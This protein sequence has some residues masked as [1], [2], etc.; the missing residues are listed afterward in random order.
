[1][2]TL[3]IMSY[4]Y[5]WTCFTFSE[6]YIVI[7]IYMCERPTRCTFSLWFTSLKLSSTCFEQV[8]VHHQEE[9]C[10]SSLQYFTMHLMRSLV[11]DTTRNFFYYYH[12][13][14]STYTMY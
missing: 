9:F 1:V 12:Y 3:K 6:P 13:I 10:T 11:G 8:T 7:H 2:A 5:V 14:C 4:V